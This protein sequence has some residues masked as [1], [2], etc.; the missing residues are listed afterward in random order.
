MNPEQVLT[1]ETLTQS[2]RKVILRGSVE[3]EN[4]EVQALSAALKDMMRKELLSMREKEASSR[5]DIAEP[6]IKAFTFCVVCTS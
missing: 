1:R 4:S 2:N 5:L 6:H 3:S